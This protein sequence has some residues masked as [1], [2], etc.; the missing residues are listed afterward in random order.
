MTD[1]TEPVKDDR[2]NYVRP[3]DRIRQGARAGG[4]QSRGLS[5][6]DHLEERIQRLE[7]W[8][9]A[10]E[11]RRVREEYAADQEAAERREREG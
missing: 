4:E 10:E 7:A 9:D 6:L 1:N 5:Y 2:G 8:K 3:E 11:A